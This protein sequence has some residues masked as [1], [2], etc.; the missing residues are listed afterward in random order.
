VTVD[1]TNP[2]VVGA[3]PVAGA[4]EVPPGAKF[5]AAFSKGMGPDTVDETTFTLVS[6][7]TTRA[8]PAE[9]SYSA[10]VK[11]AILEPAKSLRR[12]AVY[13]V[14]VTT[15]AEDQAGN[16]LDQDPNRAGEQQKAW[17]S[18]ERRQ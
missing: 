15:G 11:K 3:G 8:V 10:A 12:G 13:R 7:G 14:T 5:T 2:K 9:V 4:K 17:T 6:K 16:G 1:T 18:T